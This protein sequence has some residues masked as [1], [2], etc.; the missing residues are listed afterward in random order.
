MTVCRGIPSIDFQF[1]S[2]NGLLH[3]FGL[4]LDDGGE[5][6]KV[7]GNVYLSRA[8]LPKTLRTPPH[9]RGLSVLFHWGSPFLG[10]HPRV[11]SAED[12]KTYV[13]QRLRQLSLAENIGI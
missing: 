8:D 11:P 5:F 6:D 12:V 10:N 4:S 13:K 3:S 1:P 7:V 9:F 2:D